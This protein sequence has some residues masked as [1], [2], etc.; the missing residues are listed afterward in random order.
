MVLLLL[1]LIRTGQVVQANVLRGRLRLRRHGN[2]QLILLQRR[3]RRWLLLLRRRRLRLVYVVVCSCGGS[4]GGGSGGGGGRAT[5][6]ATSPQRWRLLL[7]G[8]VQCPRVRV[9]VRDGCWRG[10][11]GPPGCKQVDGAVTT[12][13]RQW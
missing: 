8:Y 4:D 3:W 6:R 10:D 1:R 2:G 12:R 9:A 7:S 13:L 5:V 11:R